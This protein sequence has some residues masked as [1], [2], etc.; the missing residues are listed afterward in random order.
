MLRRRWRLR[1]AATVLVVAAHTGF[2]VG[3]LALP[4]RGT[5]EENVHVVPGEERPKSVVKF[6]DCGPAGLALLGKTEGSQREDAKASCAELSKERAMFAA[7]AVAACLLFL[8][9]IQWF[10]RRGTRGMR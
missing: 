2:A 5:S 3:S 7:A 8:L 1:V 4:V 10:W 9:V 6:V